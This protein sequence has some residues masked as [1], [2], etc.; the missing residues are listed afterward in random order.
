[1][2]LSVSRR[3]GLILTAALASSLL[4]T[5]ALAGC[6]VV[7]GL[8]ENVTGGEVDLGGQSVPKDFPSEVPLAK[9]DIVYG[10]SAGK[11]G[12]KIWNVTVKVNKGA[13]DDI[14]AQLTAAGFT[15]AEGTEAVADGTGGA[16]TSDKYGVLVV[17]TDDGSN[18]TV[19]NY[20]VTSVNK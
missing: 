14:S 2:S 4:L 8:V 13:F 11:E 1:M 16:F 19:A 3:R 5:P 17:V 9:G 12:D 15:R 10:L 7:E 18:G 6:S 20:T